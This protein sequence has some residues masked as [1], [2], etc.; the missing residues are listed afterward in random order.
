M[1][2][3]GRENR[4]AARPADTVASRRARNLM[5]RAMRRGLSTLLVSSRTAAAP[6]S[7]A[8]RTPVESPVNPR[9]ESAFVIGAGGG[10]P[11]LADTASDPTI[12]RSTTP[13][14]SSNEV[15]IW[16]AAA[17][18]SRRRSRRPSSRN[19]ADHRR[20]G[21]AGNFHESSAGSE[22]PDKNLPGDYQASPS[23]QS[24]TN[25]PSG[26][27]SVVTGST[28]TDPSSSAVRTRPAGVSTDVG[29]RQHT[30]P[31]GR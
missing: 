3:S 2:V 21:H 27:R 13:T 25:S 12:P 8:M 6:D 7:P 28:N 20:H 5:E 31:R 26:S 15:A 29:P 30:Q 16:I 14:M 4:R 19:G 18:A 10:W 11:L 24:H 9:C 23:R 22:Q 17:S 1:N